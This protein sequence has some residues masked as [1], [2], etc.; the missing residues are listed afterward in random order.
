MKL[1]EKRGSCT[2][3][4]MLPK[5][6]MHTK[7]YKYAKVKDKYEINFYEKNKLI[8][9]IICLKEYEEIELEFLSFNSTDRV[10]V[11]LF[12][13]DSFVEIKPG[14]KKLITPIGYHE[15][16]FVP[17]DYPIR[18]ET[19]N[20]VFE[21]LY[22]IVPK[23]MDWDNLMNLRD[24]LEKKL[25]GLSY[26]LLKSRSGTLDSNFEDAPH[27]LKVYQH[28]QKNLKKISLNMESII[29]DPIKDIV[30]IYREKN[31]S[32]KPDGKS[33]RWLSKKG[34][35]KNLNHLSP[36]YFYEKHAE[37]TENNLENRWIKYIMKS[38]KLNLNQLKFMFEK[39]LDLQSQ[40]LLAKTKHVESYQERANSLI[41][42]LGYNETKKNLQKLIKHEK[43]EIFSISEQISKNNKN[44]FELKK[45]ITK[46]ARY[47]N[48][49]ILL[50]IN[51]SI[52][53]KKPTMR[54]L[55]DSRYAEVYRFHKDIESFKKNTTQ[56]NQISFPIKRTSLLFEYYVLCMIIDILKGIGFV[57]KKGWLAES[58]DPLLL[59]GS[60]TSE[61][62]LVLENVLENCYIEL[63]YDTRILDSDETR[64]HF[65]ANINK[66]PD[67]RVSIY[68]KKG[69]F[70]NTLILDAKYRNHRYLW[71]ENEKNDVMQQLSDYL[72][73]WHYDAQKSVSNKLNRS[74]VHKVVAVY[75]K[76]KGI[77]PYF[78]K[79]D[80]TLVFVQIEPVDPESSEEPFGYSNLSSIINEFFE[81]TLINNKLELEEI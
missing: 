76:Q 39:N 66:T 15:D 20:G 34:K 26:D 21:A 24:Y 77:E 71:D 18:L 81:F 25:I 80:N 42:S 46:F 10:I 72:R 37:L 56:V 63:A 6:I 45:I 5:V 48:A 65:K 2:S 28:V 64:S 3:M 30:Q 16:M 41:Q 9:N 36:N 38:T 7:K 40:K 35:S 70:L 51:S 27:I 67:F 50:K 53:N 49:P 14:E 33:Q 60:L 69:I 4:T 31:H 1:N 12:N 55:K 44:L 23:N 79:N 22:R 8:E 61:T 68:N 57:W 73:I 17:G 54:L 11:E 58:T 47:E 13:S 43:S 62:L 29:N 59:I 19:I 74:A 78:E 75:P 32:R 52:Y